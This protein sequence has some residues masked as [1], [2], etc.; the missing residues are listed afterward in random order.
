MHRL[1][2][3]AASPAELTSKRAKIATVAALLKPLA[4]S[5]DIALD[6]IDWREAVPDMGRSEQV[7][8]DQLKPTEWDVF[9]GLLWHRFGTPTG[10]RDPQTQ[11]PYLSGTEEDFF[12]QFDAAGGAHP[13]LHQTYDTLESFEKMLLKHLQE[14]L[15]G[16]SEQLRGK[17]VS[18]EVVLSLAPKMPNNL[19]CRA[20][21]FGR[22]KDMAK[23]RGQGADAANI[24]QRKPRLSKWRGTSP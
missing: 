20:A 3:F 18:P 21:F 11:Q 5:L 1:R 24:R 7:I 17:P 9:I 12:A 15:I 19:P 8:L 13:G 2:V 10:A 22:E 6:V 14:L 16:Y 23:V 4:D